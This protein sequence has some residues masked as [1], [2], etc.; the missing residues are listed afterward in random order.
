MK[1]PPAIPAIGSGESHPAASEPSALSKR[2]DNGANGEQKPG[3]IEN[4]S[5]QERE[6]LR[7][8]ASGYSTT[9]IGQL[10]ALDTGTVSGHRQQIMAKLGVYS[11]AGLTKFALGQG[12]WIG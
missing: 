1:V 11:I 4:L 7:M 6:I 5:I 2:A 3:S 9:E 10:L 8:I 12:L